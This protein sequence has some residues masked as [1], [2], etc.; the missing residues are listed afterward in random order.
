MTR[1]RDFELIASGLDVQ[2]IIDRIES[3]PGLWDEIT[4]RQE[5]TATAH[6]DTKT[7]F[8]RGPYKFTLYYYLFDLGSYDYPVMDDLQDVLVPVLTPLLKDELQVTELGR[9]LIVNLKAGGYIK[10]HIDEGKYADH[11]SRFHVALTGNNDCALMVGQDKQHMKPGEAWW[12]NHK[13]EHSAINAGQT[14][15]WHIIIDAVTSRFPMGKV[16]VSDHSP[17]TVPSMG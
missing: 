14:D 11:F 4:A 10:P 5:F 9:V 15:R 1:M 17:T 13:V 2:P 12:F 6:R 3:M 16:P 7:I 8:V